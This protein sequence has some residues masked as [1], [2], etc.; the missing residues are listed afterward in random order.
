MKGDIEQR[1][2]E[3][4]NNLYKKLKIVNL[5]SENVLLDN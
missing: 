4:A 5:D 1:K 3:F 2:N